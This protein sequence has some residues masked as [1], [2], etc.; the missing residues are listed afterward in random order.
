MKKTYASVL[1]LILAAMALGA[2]P[3][4][5]LAQAGSGATGTD[6]PRDEAGFQIVPCSGVDAVGNPTCDYAQLI[7]MADRIIRFLLYMSIPLVL[8][9]IMWTAF[10]YLTANGDPG[11]L[12][13]AKKMLK[14]VA[15]GLFWVLGSYIV[16]YTVL[17]SLLADQIGEE[18]KQSF[19][20]KFF[21]E[22]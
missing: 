4:V 8:G 22:Q 3:L 19:L 9:I 13:D 5:A 12:A 20:R 6:D 1:G 7:R 17:D 14:Y 10:K 2:S 18:S 21:G 11:K 16:V 15:I